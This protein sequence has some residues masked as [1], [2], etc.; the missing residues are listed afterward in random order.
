MDE[1]DEANKLDIDYIGI[2][3]VFNTSTKTDTAAPFGLEGLK[4]AVKRSIHPAVGIGGMN[5][6][7]AE[8]VIAC[9]AD[10]IAVVSAIMEATNPQKAAS[11]LM[12]KITRS[13]DEQRRI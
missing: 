4:E 9:G 12:D 1:I 11:E 3:P 2:S 6:A 8:S 7:T 10:G 5:S 13:R